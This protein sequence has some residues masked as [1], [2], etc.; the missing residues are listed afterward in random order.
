M[1]YHGAMLLKIVIFLAAVFALFLAVRRLFLRRPTRLGEQLKAVK[2]EIDVAIN[3]LIVVIACIAVFA[4]GR[5]V[6]AWWTAA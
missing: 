1:R 3:I 5:M 6:W 4:I 2:R